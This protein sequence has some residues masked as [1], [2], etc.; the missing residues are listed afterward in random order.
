MAIPA[1]AM[2]ANYDTAKL[3]LD[4]AQFPATITSISGAATNIANAVSAIVAKMN[5]VTLGWAGTTADE[6]TAFYTAWDLAI[7]QLFGN[8]STGREERDVDAFEGLRSRLLDGHRPAR[9]AHGSAGGSAGGEQSKVP[10]RKLP[11]GQDLDHRST[12]D[13]RGADDRDGQRVMVR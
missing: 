6:V 4:L 5:E 9:G 8:G 3:D 13:A 12:D 7:R 11:F 2:P 1:A 10:Y